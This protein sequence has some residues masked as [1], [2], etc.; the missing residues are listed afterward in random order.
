VDQAVDRQLALDGGHRALDPRVVGGQEPDQ[1][2]QEQAGVQVVGPVVLHEGVALA[3]VALAADLV[4]ELAADAPPAV[5]RALA[6]PAA[7]PP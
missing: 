7:R 4:V 6:G 1:R 2:D 3:V 5:H